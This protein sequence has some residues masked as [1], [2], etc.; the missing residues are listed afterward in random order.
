MGTLNGRW[1]GILE[2]QVN[3]SSQT[4]GEKKEEDGEFLCLMSVWIGFTTWRS[5]EPC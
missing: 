3:T 1:D 2:G 4:S 5:L